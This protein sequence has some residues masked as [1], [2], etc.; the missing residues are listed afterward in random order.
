MSDPRVVNL[1]LISHTNA[2]K[3]TLARTLLGRDVGEV[4]DAPHV[5]DLSDAHVMIETA[6]GCALRLWDT[7]GFGDTARLAKRLKQSGNPLGWV[8]TQVWDRFRDRPLWCSQQAMRNARDEADVVLY[9]VNAAEAPE[10]AGYVALEMEILGWI[11]K[12]VIL[13]LNQT[14][15]PHAPEQERADVRRW[16]RHLSAHAVVRAV[17]GL[18]AF[19]RC[20]VQEGELLR[21]VGE[22]LPI[23]KQDAYAQLAGAWR[24]KNLARFH[25]SMAVL[26]RQ[27]AAAAADREELERKPWSEKARG[28]VRSLASGAD[29]EQ[30]QKERAMAALAERLDAAIRSA[31]DELIALHQLEGHAAAEIRRRL[32]ED[33]AAAE[34]VSEGVAA[35]IGG[36]VSGALGGLA[37]GYNL[38]KGRTRASL[39]WSAEFFEGLVRSALLRYLA[40]IHFGRGRGD[41]AAAEHPA[42][43]QDAV[44]AC[45]AGRRDAFRDVWERGGPEGGTE[46]AAQDLEALLSECVAELLERFYP[47]AEPLISRFPVDGSTPRD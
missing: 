24:D 17:L 10:D 5:T 11:G 31:T 6:D 14:G 15:P 47:D 2:G 22:L 38:V 37:R 3:T 19:A 7:P 35:A 44:A 18:D 29:P 4:R 13:L 43:W 30:A 16:Q 20:W 28:F 21:T 39:R 45:T 9:L 32:R 1:S 42:F 27:L 41:F 46:D 23:E 8:L 36:F 40:V 25:E 33:Y 34:P 26:A 12:P